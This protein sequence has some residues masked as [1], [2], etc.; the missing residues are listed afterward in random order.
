MENKTHDNNTLEDSTTGPA[1][2]VLS[3]R[4]F[5]IAKAAFGFRDKHR[6]RRELTVSPFVVQG[7]GPKRPRAY[8]VYR[9]SHSR[10]YLPRHYGL[11]EFG[12]ADEERIPPGEPAPRLAFRGSLRPLQVEAVEAFMKTIGPN[13]VGTPTPTHPQGGILSLYCGAGKTVI[14]L[15]LAALLGRKTLIVVHKE[16]LMHQWHERIRDFLPGATVGLIQQKKVDVA[17]KDIVIAMLQSLAI[18]DYEPSVLA[19]FGL[20]IFDEA[21]HLSS[22]IFS[23]A[24]PKIG[25]PVT[26]GLS[27]TPRRADGLTKVFKWFLGEIVYTA[28]RPRDS[29]VKP[30]AVVVTLDPE[31]GGYGDVK[32]ARSG[33]VNTAGMI[34]S[35]TASVD[36]T[37]LVAELA[38]GLAGLHPKRQVLVLS[39]R[40]QHLDDLHAA[41]VDADAGISVGFYV[42][43]MNQDMLKE[44]ESRRIV[45]ATYSMAAEGLD[46]KTLNTLLLASPM[47]NVVQAVGR[48]LRKVDH[49]VPPLIVDVAD[50][51]SVFCRQAGNRRRI[52]KR[53]GFADIRDASPTGASG[54]W[55]SQAAEL[56]SVGGGTGEGGQGYDSVIE[57]MFSS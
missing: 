28:E 48:I 54:T 24:L 13:G 3:T 4:G 35:I 42:G 21:H 43:G 47:S 53:Q 10:L 33:T 50:A 49:E 12:E 7:Y 40:R 29:T 9:E 30:S 27:A 16:F 57:A 18:R 15:Y 25:A 39:G 5:G 37:C 41:L 46:I 44:A 19:G 8:P 31:A 14:A 26:L 6:C 45:L 38:R 23:R 56:L 51:Y 2:T 52:F 17:G 22:E 20:A 55:A 34:S 1:K 36:R 11:K 32:Y